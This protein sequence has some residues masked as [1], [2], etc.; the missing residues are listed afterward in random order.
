MTG[1][2][3]EAGALGEKQGEEPG[4]H[5]PLGGAPRSVLQTQIE[6]WMSISM[7]TWE[8]GHNLYLPVKLQYPAL[9]DWPLCGLIAEVSSDLG[10][11][12]TGAREGTK[13][14]GEALRWAMKF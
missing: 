11:L 13:A 3:W 7:V 6:S 12:D 1:R 9:Q 5:C 2:V 10:R 8:T 14:K 4:F